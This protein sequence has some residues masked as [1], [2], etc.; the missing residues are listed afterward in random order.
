MW[1][2]GRIIPARSKSA[3]ESEVRF[4]STDFLQLHAVRKILSLGDYLLT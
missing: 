3:S 2:G 4:V 1:K